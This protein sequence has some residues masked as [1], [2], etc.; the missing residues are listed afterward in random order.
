MEQLN[1]ILRILPEGSELELD[2][3]IYVTGTELIGELIDHEI[4]PA[5]MQAGDLIEY[6]LIHQKNNTAVHKQLA[7][8][9]SEIK[10]GDMILVVPKMKAG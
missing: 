8:V 9:D 6:D 1:I 10:D 7:F 4:I 5:K 3:S 2:V